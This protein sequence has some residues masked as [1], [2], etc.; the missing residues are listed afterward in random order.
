VPPH[1]KISMQRLQIAAT[2][3]ALFKLTL[4]FLEAQ[5]LMNSIFYAFFDVLESHMK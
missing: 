1:E 3:A 2:A 4:K 5:Q